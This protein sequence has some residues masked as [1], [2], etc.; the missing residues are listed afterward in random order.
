MM[1]HLPKNPIQHHEGIHDQ[2]IPEIFE[3][4][5]YP[6]ATFIEVSKAQVGELDGRV[7]CASFQETNIINELTN[8]MGKYRGSIGITHRRR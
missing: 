6:C 8:R 7:F 4:S 1:L 2:S 5:G 3:L